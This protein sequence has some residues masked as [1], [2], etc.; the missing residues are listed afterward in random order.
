MYFTYMINYWY[1]S[2]QIVP[3]ILDD[4]LRQLGQ[5]T[6]FDAHECFITVHRTWAMSLRRQIV[7][8]PPSIVEQRDYFIQYQGEH[9]C[10]TEYECTFTMIILKKNQNGLTLSEDDG[11]TRFLCFV[12][13]ALHGQ[14]KI[15]FNSRSGA[16]RI[17]PIYHE[18]VCQSEQI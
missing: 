11:S 10:I 2:W 17:L 14:K 13:C 9:Y 4:V 1:N 7:V 12:A 8:Q 15:F 5:N 3:P 6:F 16:E 18:V